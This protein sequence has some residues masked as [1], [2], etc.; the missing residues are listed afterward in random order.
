MYF[1]FVSFSR[2]YLFWFSLT[3]ASLKP[4]INRERTNT[5]RVVP[6]LISC[7]SSRLDCF[8]FSLVL[9]SLNEY[10]CLFECI[11]FAYLNSHTA[12]HD[13]CQGSNYKILFLHS[14]FIHWFKEFFKIIKLK[15]KPK[16]LTDGLITRTKQFPLNSAI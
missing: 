7:Y 13:V 5:F 6:K 16:C 1:C 4:H 2:F 12:H 14:G 11:S 10:Y 3:V 8:F 9:V 15:S